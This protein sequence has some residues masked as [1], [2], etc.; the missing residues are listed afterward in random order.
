MARDIDLTAVW[1]PHDQ[2]D[3]SLAKEIRQATGN[4]RPILASGIEADG[5]DLALLPAVPGLVTSSTGI[6]EAVGRDDAEVVPY[7]RRY[8]AEAGQLER[9]EQAPYLF[10]VRVFAPLQWQEPIKDWLDQQHFE[11]QTTM[12]GVFYGE[13]YEP[14][15]G[16]FH[17]F[18]LWAIDHPD[19]IDSP[20]WIRVR[21]T[22]WYEDVLP[23]FQ[24]SMVR[25][26]IY[27]ILE[28]DS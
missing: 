22:S 1:L 28:P 20:E 16:P 18:N 2:G 12:D 26:E 24:A 21:A 6:A 14:L 11:H 23:G 4:G 25:R 10:C 8:P 9:F 7:W 15:D 5:E 3:G 13:G 27:R 19:R 17:F